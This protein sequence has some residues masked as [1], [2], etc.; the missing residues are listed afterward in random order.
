MQEKFIIKGGKRLKGVIDIKG[1]KNA[2]FPLL[3]STILTREPCII[4]GLPL[5]KDVERM[6]FILE[7]MGAKIKRLA[8]RD[9]EVQC[10]DI[11]PERIPFEVMGCFRGSILLWGALLARFENFKTPSPGGC[12]I[13]ARPVF[14]HLDAFKDMGVNITQKDGFF[15]FERDERIKKEKEPQVVILSE[16]S[17]TAT[18]N[19]LL[20]ASSLKRKTV[21][22]I[23]DEDY[24]VQELVKV[25]RKMG[26][27]IKM[28]G[29][30]II[31]IEGQ[32]KLK[33]FEHRLIS[34]PIE[35]GTFI[36]A[37]LATKGEIL[38]ENVEIGHL[39]FFLNKLI[40]AGA[41]LEFPNSRSVRVLQSPPLAICKI[42][43]LPYPGLATDLQPELGVLA[44]Q[45]KGSTLIHDPLYE[46]RLKYLENLNKMGADIIF[47]DPHRAIINGPTPLYGTEFS[48]LDLRSGAA[49]VIA[50]LVANGTTIIQNIDQLDRG[51]EKIEER[52]RQLGADIKRVCS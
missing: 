51:Y 2:A 16:F 28:K 42:Q 11:N 5:I 6:I 38:L 37:A 22:K 7:K 13:G 36:I 8:E 17:V 44:T 4:R 25:L 32:E 47:C 14:A 29:F 19:V 21:L 33:G 15:F 48:S 50:G 9:L 18:E 34:D 41:R 23:A 10:E 43:S 20:F 30:H 1:A 52:L 12:I 27:R 46:G 45:A 24:Q 39:Y 49:L 26:A 40:K 35:A 31:E 3:A